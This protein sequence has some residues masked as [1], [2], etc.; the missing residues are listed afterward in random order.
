M[1]VE[2]VD[3]AWEIS[4]AMRQLLKQPKSTDPTWSV[5]QTALG[6]PIEASQYWDLISVLNS[7]LQRLNSLIGSVKDFE[8]DDAKKARALSAV[9]TF[10]MVF[11]PQQQ[12]QPWKSTLQNFLKEDD[13]LQ[14]DWFSIIAKRHQPLR[15]LSDEDRTK[16]IDKIDEVLVSI[17]KK[18]DIPDWAKAPLAEGLRRFRFILI[19]LTFFGCETAID[20]LLKI[21]SQAEAVEAEMVGASAAAEKPGASSATLLAILTVV[22]LA[23]N[24]FSMSDQAYTAFKT[25]KGWYLQVVSENPKLPK[26]N[27]LLI[28]G[29]RH[30]SDVPPLDGGAT[31][32]AIEP[33]VP[34][35]EKDAKPAKGK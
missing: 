2:I 20:E 9:R 31:E 35:V 34:V 29:P 1:K 5:F 18:G 14:L 24:L 4:Q 22:S 23:A 11:S 8:F 28:E 19:H 15:K 7:R 33:D 21:Y 27:R 26:P 17:D 16:L 32:V 13:A 6:G 30:A 10:S 3:P 25:Y 12:N